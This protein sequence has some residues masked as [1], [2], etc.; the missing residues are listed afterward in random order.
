MDRLGL[1]TRQDHRQQKYANTLF[2]HTR[3]NSVSTEMLD[4]LYTKRLNYWSYQ[5]ID[6]LDTKKEKEEEIWLLWNQGMIE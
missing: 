6:R 4:S 5:S 3:T 2:S 1:V